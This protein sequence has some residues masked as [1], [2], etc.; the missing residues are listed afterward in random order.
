[1]QLS[2]T[3]YSQNALGWVA[4]VGIEHMLTQKLSVRLEYLYYGFPGANA[5]ASALGPDRV[6]LTSSMQEARFGLNIKF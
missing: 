1:V 4:G 6:T 5:P 2:G 3:G